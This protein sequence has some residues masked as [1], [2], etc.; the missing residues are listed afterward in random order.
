VVGFSRGAYNVEYD[1]GTTD[2]LKSIH[3]RDVIPDEY[4][5]EKLLSYNPRT[6]KFLVRWKG[7]TE[8]DDSYVSFNNLGGSW[9]EEAKRLKRQTN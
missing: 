8:D 3:E 6:K 2:V 4:T 1:N 9:R 7:F 5:V